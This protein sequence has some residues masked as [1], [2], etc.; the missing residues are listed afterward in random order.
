MARKVAEELKKEQQELKEQKHEKLLQKK[1][2][3]IQRKRHLDRQ[4]KSLSSELTTE[5]F[6]AH[7][8]KIGNFILTKA[9]PPLLWR[10]VKLNPALERAVE[11]NRNRVKVR[12]L[13]E[14]ETHCGFQ[15]NS[16]GS[17]GAGTELA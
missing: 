11:D 13:S 12:Q 2:E 6:A 16:K 7:E 3:E 4:V 14:V 10:P 5:T 9:E 8:K 1:E 15:R 17:P